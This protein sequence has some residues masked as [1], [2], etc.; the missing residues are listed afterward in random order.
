[1][2]GLMK[3]TLSKIKI[4]DLKPSFWTTSSKDI[5][6]AIFLVVYIK[7]LI[8]TSFSKII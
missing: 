2:Q 5:N 4:K 1:M 6:Q 3:I 7:K 8:K